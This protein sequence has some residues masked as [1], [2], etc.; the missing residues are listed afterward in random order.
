M[1]RTFTINLAGVNYHVEEPAYIILEEYLHS[2]RQ[3][4]D[5]EEDKEEIMH[6]IESRISELISERKSGYNEVID[7]EDINYVIS[8]IGSPNEFGSGHTQ[9]E[10]IPVQV[11]KKLMRDPQ[12]RVFGG[13]L[14]GLSEFLNMN[15][16]LVRVLFVIF[17]FAFGLSLLIYPIL[18][19]LI[20][21]AKTKSDFAQMRGQSITLD[22]IKS[23]QV[24][25]EFA[26]SQIFK[27]IKRALG[28]FLI[29]MGICGIF[30]AI[31]G[32]LFSINVNGDVYMDEEFRSLF[33]E[34]NRFG[35]SLAIFTV[36]AIPSIIF[37]LLGLKLLKP[38]LK[39]IGKIC[40][41]LAVMIIPISVYIGYLAFD[42][43]TDFQQE[44]NEV[45]LK[46]HKANKSRIYFD[47]ESSDTLQILTVTDPRFYGI[48]DNRS[49][50][51]SLIENDRVTIELLES[52]EKQGYYEVIYDTYD[53][54]KRKSMKA[55]SLEYYHQLVD[56]KLV[57]AN[58]IIQNK[59][60]QSKR[61]RIH[62][63]VFIAPR[64]ILQLNGRNI[65]DYLEHELESNGSEY[66]ILKED[67]LIC[68]SC[69]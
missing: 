28:Y 55:E 30:S 58:A 52:T 65:Q 18:W 17:T 62:I 59:A 48:N 15:L 38:Q 51:N 2:I 4:L 22:S 42:K 44:R 56:S 16:L 37:M 64:T 66:Y 29:F 25:V 43:A 63:K 53:D 35:L 45:E 39:H 12:K 5:S 21:K 23:G 24:Q 40:V 13:V 1:N 32:A 57:L 27:N 9:N 46:G 3:S 6:D 54:G 26:E 50:V 14:A 19:I 20:P 41:A 8:V 31:S 49:A 36:T 68:L 34:K 33:N 10:S 67:E 11:P 61:N 7:I 69:R 47:A 60:E